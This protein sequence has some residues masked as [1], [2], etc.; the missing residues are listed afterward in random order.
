MELSKIPIEKYAAYAIVAGAILLAVRFLALPLLLAGLP[1]LVAFGAAYLCRPLALRLHKF[2]RLP[3]GWLCVFLVFFFVSAICLLLFFGIR[4][5]AAE[6]AELAARLGEENFV[7]NTL[8]S[9]SAWWEGARSR[10]PFLSSLSDGEGRGALAGW[11]EN[12][13]AALGEY[14]LRAAG[15][16]AGALPAW[17]IFAFVSL[18]S[19]FYFARD[20]GKMRA[21]VGRLLPPRALAYLLRLKNSAWYAAAQYLRAYLLL[22]LLVFFALLCGFLL[23]GVPYAILLAAILA[24]LDFLPLIGLGAA[25]IPWGIVELLRGNTFLGVGLLILYAAV[26][27]LRQ[28]AEPKIIGRHFGLHPLVALAATYIGLRLFGFWGLLLLPPACLILRQSFLREA[29]HPGDGKGHPLRHVRQNVGGVVFRG[30]LVRKAKPVATLRE[31]VQLKGNLLLGE[32]ACHQKRILHRHSGVRRRVPKEDGRRMLAYVFFVGIGRALLLG[33]VVLA[34]NAAEGALVAHSI[35]VNDGVAEDRARGAVFTVSDARSLP[36]LFSLPA[37]SQRARQ[38]PACRKTK[39]KHA[40]GVGVVLLGVV[41]DPF[42]GVGRLKERLRELRRLKTA[43]SQDVGVQPCLQIGEGDRL[44]LAVKAKF[45]SAARKNEDRGARA[46]RATVHKIVYV[47]GQGRIREDPFAK[48]K[49]RCF[50]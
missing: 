24:I 41:A 10:F 46:V 44:C 27:V 32:R 14:A 29:A 2:S 33:R 20:M 17:L 26:L 16:L 37:S 35:A 3:V 42:D 19:A 7:E 15:A 40:L 34:A 18:I 23:L 39:H 22:A 13:G 31:D 1:F 6:L 50:H 45:V 43:V 38:M 11:M 21:T 28:L 49:G 30:L 5:A 25:L 9:L 8:A 12:A 48:R 47:R 4:A 36:D